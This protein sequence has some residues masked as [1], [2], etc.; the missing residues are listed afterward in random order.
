MNLKTVILNILNICHRHGR[1][2]S[3]SLLKSQCKVELRGTIGDSEFE[4]DLGKL[5]DGGFVSSI[6]NKLYGDR[7]YFI[8]DLGRAQL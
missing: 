3:K 2:S 8:T 1:M 4:A 6:D 7:L 5:V